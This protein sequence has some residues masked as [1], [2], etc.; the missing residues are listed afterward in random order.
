VPKRKSQANKHAPPVDRRPNRS[1]AALAAKNA[2]AGKSQPALAWA[3]TTLLAQPPS[4]DDL[5]VA[6]QI[7]FK[8]AEFVSAAECFRRVAEQAPEPHQPIMLQ[9]C[10]LAALGQTQQAM[11]LVQQQLPDC[12]S[13]DVLRLAHYLE[14]G[15][16]VQ[17]ASELLAQRSAE[18]GD[19]PEIQLELAR[20]LGNAGD[21]KRAVQI[22]RDG[23]T[24]LFQD[25]HHLSTAHF[26]IG[27]FLEREGAPSLEVEQAYRASIEA[28]P[29]NPRS[30]INLA[31]LWNRAGRFE[32]TL[33]LLCPVEEQFEREPKVAYLVAVALRMKDHFNQ[34]IDRL[35]RLVATADFEPAWEL[36]GRCLTE[37]ERY[38]AAVDHYRRWL[39]VKPGNPVAT[40]M[41]SAMLGEQV[42][43]R[44]SQEY[45]VETF[46]AFAET[47][48]STLLRLQYRGPQVIQQWLQQKLGP[49]TDEPTRRVL[50]AG[51]GTGLV[52]TMLRP[53]ASSLVG[54]DLSSAMLERA[55]AKQL[56]DELL[57]ADLEEYLHQH[58]GEFDLIVAADTFNYFGDLSQLLKTALSALTPQGWLIFTLEEGALTEDTFQ[59]NTHG[60]YA[61]SPAYIIERLGECGLAGGTMQ[62]LVMRQENGH[63]VFALL[64]AVQAPQTSA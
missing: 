57:C 47:F 63:S 27:I 36:L 29:D 30:Y 23:S 13:R 51:C 38:A 61:H 39:A 15:G 55:A 31:L 46:D 8:F 20:L 19:T 32:E 52:A 34:A 16:S 53:Y 59:L 5:T 43:G 45:V 4:I 48:E 35:N 11:N 26:F 49:P 1:G 6:G 41:L 33:E 64:I 25:A 56:Y 9:A 7:F 22:L 58:V 28:S 17:Q 62:R 50:D 14:Q 24:D 54:V 3:R 2:D 40:H 60:R 12:E 37:C 42:P 10:S 44:A 21:A 18:Q